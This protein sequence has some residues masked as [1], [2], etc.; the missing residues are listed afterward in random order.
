MDRTFGK[1]DEDH[2]STLESTYSTIIFLDPKFL[3]FTLFNGFVQDEEEAKSSSSDSSLN[4]VQNFLVIASESE[5]EFD[6]SPSNV[7]A[8]V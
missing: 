6:F 3:A 5:E 1:I 4:F 8:G 2:N 7:A